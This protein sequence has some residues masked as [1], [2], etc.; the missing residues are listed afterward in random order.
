MGNFDDLQK[1]T[2]GKSILNGLAPRAIKFFVL[3]PA[4]LLLLYPPLFG[5][6]GWGLA[7]GIAGFCM[8]MT[9]ICAYQEIH[10]LAKGE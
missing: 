3:I 9:A 2:G 8:T 7:G 1:I 4:G 6:E 10:F 5:L